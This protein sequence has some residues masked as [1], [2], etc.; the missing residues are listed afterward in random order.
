[1]SATSASL[2][3]GVVAS[4]AGLAVFL[5]LHH[6]W[7]K[8]IWFVTPAGLLVTLSSR[9]HVRIRQFRC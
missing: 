3:A 9:L 7:I 6:V 8:P 1:M 4:I 5:G 2:L